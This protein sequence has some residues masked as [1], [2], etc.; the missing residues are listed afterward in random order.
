MHINK[1]FSTK[2]ISTRFFCWRLAAKRCLISNNSRINDVEMIYSHFKC[3]YGRRKLFGVSTQ[4]G[5]RRMNNFALVLN[6]QWNM[7]IRME[8]NSSKASKVSKAFGWNAITELSTEVCSANRY[9]AKQIGIKASAA[10]AASYRM[11]EM[12]TKLKWLKQMFAK[13]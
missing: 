7:R 13:K 9:I 2:N 10:L 1:F 11:K 3:V 5:M 12:N 6:E 4:V 8:S